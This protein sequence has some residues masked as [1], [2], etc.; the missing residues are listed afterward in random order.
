MKKLIFIAM[1]VLLFVLVI[2]APFQQLSWSGYT[3]TWSL[4]QLNS[5]NS[6]ILF[7]AII[8]LYIM[9]FAM[10]GAAIFNAVAAGKYAAATAWIYRIAACVFTL[11]AILL[12][13]NVLMDDIVKPH[14]ML[15]IEIVLAI[16][17]T[18]ASFVIFRPAKQAE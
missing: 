5:I 1:P 7:A 8:G 6:D 9:P 15:Y 18:I 17:T 12:L 11:S 3:E 10:L 2:Y 16:S 13:V 14:F 4:T